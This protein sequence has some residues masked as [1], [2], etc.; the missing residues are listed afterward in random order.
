MTKESDH[1]IYQLNWDNRY[2]V[3]LTQANWDVW[4]PYDQLALLRK[5]IQLCVC[6][7]V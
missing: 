6:W 2:E 7:G 5:H 3:R 4:V 1:I